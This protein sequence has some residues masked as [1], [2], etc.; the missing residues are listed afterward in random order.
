MSVQIEDS[1]KELLA[2]EF[3]TPYF[4]GIKSFLHEKK[5]AGEIIYPSGSNIFRAFD[6]TP[7]DKVK[8]VIL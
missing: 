5:Q 3:D 4:Q 7:V 6:L 1:R 8:V 2:Q